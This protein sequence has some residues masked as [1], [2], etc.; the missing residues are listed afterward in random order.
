[1]ETLPA[2]HHLFLCC[3][4]VVLS[5]GCTAFRDTRPAGPNDLRVKLEL[6]STIPAGKGFRVIVK[7]LNKSDRPVRIHRPAETTFCVFTD[8]TGRKVEPR[9]HRLVSFSGPPIEETLILEPGDYEF[10]VMRFRWS[11]EHQY[12]WYIDEKSSLDLRPGTYRAHAVFRDLGD[13]I[14]ESERREIAVIPR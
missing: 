14:I 5:S 13:R 2:R 8:S 10:D 9:I 6:P 1:M 7:V 3:A 11:R 12:R 4:W